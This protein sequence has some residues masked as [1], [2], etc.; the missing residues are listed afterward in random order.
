MVGPSPSETV[1]EQM[2]SALLRP[3]VFSAATKATLECERLGVG[4]VRRR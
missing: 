3:T 1:G 4:R 2:D